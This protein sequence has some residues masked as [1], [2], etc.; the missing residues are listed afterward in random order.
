MANKHMKQHQDYLLQKLKIKLKLDTSTH[1]QEQL[2]KKYAI[3][4]VG[5]DV[6]T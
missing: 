3:T 6:E 1:P 4:I 5:K 2:N